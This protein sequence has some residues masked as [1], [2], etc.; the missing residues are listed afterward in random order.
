MAW[1]VV[2]SNET[3]MGYHLHQTG[4]WT[5]MTPH[6]L[7]NESYTGVAADPSD[8]AGLYVAVGPGDGHSDYEEP[9]YKLRGSGT[10]IFSNA[11]SSWQQINNASRVAKHSS[12]PWWLPRQFSSAT[13]ALLVRGDALLA[14]TWYGVWPVV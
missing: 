6:P 4:T 1:Q 10:V 13:S 11:S 3:V 8:P 9:I 14:S 12:V 5:D 7:H 2:T